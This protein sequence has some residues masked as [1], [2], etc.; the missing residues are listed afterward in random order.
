MRIIARPWGAMDRGSY[1]PGYNL[2]P[3]RLW[4]ALRTAELGAPAQQCDA[5]ED[6]LEVDGH[7]RGQYLQRMRAVANRRLVLAPGGDQPASAEA[8]ELLSEALTTTNVED[9][10][11]HMMDAIFFGYSGTEIAWRY[12]RELDLVVPGWFILAEH[13]RFRFDDRNRPHLLTETNTYPGDE[14]AAGRWIWAQQ[15]ARIAQRAGLMRTACWWSLFKRMQVRDWMVFAEKFGIPFV[16]GQYEE[17]ASPETRRALLAAIEMIGT[18]GQAILS[19][20]TKV[21]IESAMRGG[22][23]G[24]L[25]PKIAEFCNAEISKVLVGATLTTETGGPGSFALGKVHQTRS[26]ALSYS[27]AFWIER[28]FQR[29]V[30][31]PFVRF[32]PRLAGARAPELYI[33]VQ[34]EMDPLTEQQ[35]AAGLQAMGLKL[36]AEQLYRRFGYRRPATPDD[37]LKPPAPD[38]PP[39]G[40]VGGGKEGPPKRAKQDVEWEEREQLAA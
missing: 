16:L 35:V 36:S 34:P 5:F 13:R 1:R 19:D 2:T 15:R 27:D 28:L 4:A 26:D 11:W 22:D 21:A 30:C 32:N 18:E 20:A 14:L 33:H 40:K 17:R 23:V 39:G 8:A 29:A 3:D 7:A 12:S 25:H 31:E 24:S 37:E 9:A 10:I 6:L 38:I